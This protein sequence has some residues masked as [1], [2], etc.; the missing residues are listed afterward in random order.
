MQDFQGTER[1]ELIRQLGGGGMGLVYEVADREHGGRRVALKQL[2]QSDGAA[3]MRLKREFRSLADIRHPNL[4]ALYELVVEPETAFFT[5]ELVEGTTFRRWVADTISSRRPIARDAPTQDLVAPVARADAPTV[6]ARP[7]PKAQDPLDVPRLRS[8]LRQLALGVHAIHSAGQLHRDLKPSN[9]MVTPEG[10]IVILDF[11][12]ARDLE[13]AAS[14]SEQAGEVI[15]GTVP[16]M[17]PEQALGEAVGPPADWYAFGVILFQA[18]TG[19]LPFEG[20]AMQVLAD[21]QLRP[22]PAPRELV[23]DVEPEL[24][25]L[26]VGLLRT[27]PRERPVAAEVLRVLGAEAPRASTPRTQ[28]ECLGRDAELATLFS[29]LERSRRGALRVVRLVG[30]SGIGKTTLLRRFREEAE[31]QGVRFLAGRCHERESVPFKTLDAVVESLATMLAALPAAKVDALL[32][33]DAHALVRM[34]PVF[35]RV[36]AF[37]Q[38]PAR[39]MGEAQEQRRRAAAALRELVT[40]LADRVPLV[41]MVDDAQWGDLDSAVLLEELLRGDTPP[42][43]LVIVASRTDGEVLPELSAPSTE[44]VLG[45]LDRDAAAAL[46]LA[47][48]GGDRELARAAVRDAGGNPALLLQVAEAGRGA[49]LD[50]V[51]AARLEPLPTASRALLDVVAVAGAPVP[52]A[53]AVQAAGLG[54]AELDAVQVLKAARLVRGLGAG[55]RMEAWHE[56]IREVV[57]SRLPV[58]RVRELHGRLADALEAQARVDIDAVARHLEAAGLTGRA[59]EATVTAARRAASLLAFDRAAELYRRALALAT[60]EESRRRELQSALGDALADAGRGVEAAQA[61][62]DAIAA[63]PSPQAL[64]D[65]QIEQ[66]TELQRR[67][68]EQLLRS[69]RVDEGID[70]M[71]G[72]LAAVGLSLPRTPR[73][74]VLSLLW[75][76]FRIRLRGLGF[77]ETPAAHVP[78]A[79]LR[80]I[81]A[82]WSVSVGL[83]MVDTIRGAAFQSQQLLLALEAG[84]PYR[85]ARALAAEAAYLATAGQPAQE[86]A[87]A[88]IDRARVLAE[89]VGDPRLLGLVDFCAGL[90]RFLVG[91]WRDTRE[92]AARAEQRFVDSGAAVSWEATSARLFSV[93]SLFFLGEIGE[94]GR[95]I[96]ALIEEAEGRGDL[97]ALASLNSGLANVALLARDEPEA[98]RAAVRGVMAG[99]SERSFHFQ[100]Y[101][102]LLSEGLIDLYQGQPEDAWA[103]LV[104]AWPALEASQLLRIQNVRIEALGLK[105]RL[106]VA[107]GRQAVLA[108]MVARLRKEE[109]PWA[110][111]SSLM[112]EALAPGGSPEGLRQAART[113]DECEMRLQAAAV[114]LRLAELEDRP[115]EAEL[116][117]MTGQGIVAPRKAAGMLVPRWR[118]TPGLLRS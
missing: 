114:R 108:E 98:A 105:G 75:R 79:T 23:T 117:W 83:S 35:Q 7:A 52:E 1:Y 6:V 13:Q 28:G 68:A 16:Y 9:V 58:D 95:R 100:H 81:D 33:R 67:A 44:L 65:E 26:C 29:E 86:R 78:D 89:K 37:A 61:Y 107:T 59:L 36:P 88:L 97:Y 12:L 103:R 56:R 113:F 66:V 8:G 43:L 69:G 96:P 11:G 82:C 10:R 42:A 50:E 104:A 91:A 73:L 84:E 54:A 19:K 2:R 51:V 94:L 115:P 80:R 18:L 90:T 92:L 21:K 74:A 110:T 53:V 31:G 72:V 70:A 112:L 32:P 17:A 27:D 109:V 77:V 47:A 46:A 48:S 4:A 102:A 45:P 55:A 25:A 15:V 62:R 22:A 24:D 49:R 20:P 34:F 63:A 57:T 118:A 30:Q 38:A 40:R 5:M 93:W 14:L 101:W 111:A 3:L 41:V 60:P 39:P 85:V 106:A 116:A 71:E 64:P 87:A 99:W 76:R